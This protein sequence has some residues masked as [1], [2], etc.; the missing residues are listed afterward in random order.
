MALFAVVAA[1]V[2]GWIG[3]LATGRALTKADASAQRAEDNLQVALEAFE[4]VF[5]RVAGSDTSLIGVEDPELEM[6]PAVVP[7][8]TDAALL[9]DMLGFYER[10]ARQNESGDRLRAETAN[11]Y[12]RVG[13]IERR[14][15]R[16]DRAEKALRR[17]LEIYDLMAREYF[18]SG[19]LQRGTGCGVQR[20][21]FRTAG[22]RPIPGVPH[23]G[24]V[25]ALELLQG[26]E[27][28]TGKFQA[29][30]AHLALGRQLAP[31]RQGPGSG[32]GGCSL[33]RRP[34]SPHGPSKRKNI[35]AT[36]CNWPR[37]LSAVHRATSPTS[38]RWPNRTRIWPLCS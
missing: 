15:G 31:Q 29:I 33:S 12:R 25:R 5:D 19:P 13:E 4:R 21:G 7:S 1:A 27:S 37:S 17:S 24:F 36:L 3:Y 34:R 18:R 14:M 35:S 22:I 26:N 11:A 28:P 16:P 23:G 9:E 6:F 32:L 20:V 8:D 10:Y 38:W 2:V 30:R